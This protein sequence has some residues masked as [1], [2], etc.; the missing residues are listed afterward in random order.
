MKLTKKGKELLA[1]CI[2]EGF[3]LKFTRAA[4]GSGELTIE[5]DI[6]ELTELKC[7]EM[8]LPIVAMKVVGDGTANIICHLSNA[9]LARSFCCREHALFAYD[10][11]GQEILFSYRNVGEHYDFIPAAGKDIAKNLFLDFEIEIQDAENVTAVLDMSLH[12]INSV[13]F[14]EHIKSSRPHPNAPSKL[15]DVETT[16]EIWVTDAGDSHLHKISVEDFRKV[17]EIAEAENDLDI[18]SLQ[19]ELGLAANILYI[20]D[21][22]NANVS[23]YFKSKVTS[24]AE[25][26]NLL[27]VENPEKLRT[28]ASYVLS[29]GVLAEK[30]TVASVLRNGG[31]YYAQLGAA[32]ANTY[33]VRS[34]YL[35]R[36]T[37]ESCG[38]FEKV[39]GGTRFSGVNANLI[40]T[41]E[42]EKYFEIEGAG[43]VEGDALTLV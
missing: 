4:L 16:S 21:F 35:Y 20:E 25:H 8:W 22:A 15:N 2:A 11:E 14:E 13:D 19:S 42:M 36:T 10:E 29:D 31:G 1:K 34:L 9:E 28:G 12:Y 40:R 39:W 23:D 27:G 24:Y 37:P 3:E 18:F 5:D 41:M 33:N 32:V 43:A 6:Y 30:V 38:K 26:G 7:F 17:L